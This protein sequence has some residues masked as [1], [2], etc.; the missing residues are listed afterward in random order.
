[1]ATTLEAHVRPALMKLRARLEKQ[2]IASVALMDYETYLRSTLWKAIQQWVLERDNFSCVIC[3]QSKLGRLL[4]VHVHHRSYELSTFEGRNASQL[5]TLC[6]WCHGK[7][8]FYS[9]GEKRVSIQE[10]ES[11]YQR[12]A[13]L[14]RSIVENGLPLQI[15]KRGASGSASFS[16]HYVGPK[17]YLEFYALG[18]LMAELICSLYGASQGKLRLPIRRGIGKRTPGTGPYIIDR[19]TKKIVVKTL[20]S[21]DMA[22]VKV[23]KS[24]SYPVQRHF[25][26]GIQQAKYWR[27]ESTVVQPSAPAAA[28][29]KRAHG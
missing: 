17:G 23:S 6:G 29:A 8:E 1:M 24:C 25:M 28:L 7:V 3:G 20:C 19:T 26:K 22:E 27:I 15:R 11:E 21:E 9:S 18:S 4:E 10:K 5:V 16:V 14:H 12:L 2:G 13:A